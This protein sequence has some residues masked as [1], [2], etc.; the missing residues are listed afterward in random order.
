MAQPHM[1]LWELA[2]SEDNRVFSPYVW[3]VKL[4]LDAKVISL[5]LLVVLT[6]KHPN[7]STLPGRPCRS[8]PR[9][10][11]VAGP[12]VREGALALSSERLDP[13]VPDGTIPDLSMSRTASLDKPKPQNKFHCSQLSA[14]VP[15]LDVHG[16]RLHESWDIAQY[17]ETEFPGT[18]AF[19]AGDAPPDG[20]VKN[21]Q[22]ASFCFVIELKVLQATLT[23]RRSRPGEVRCPALRG[24]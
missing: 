12:G 23:L 10:L 13:A 19:R 6:V 24:S 8:S 11:R 17:L 16:K 7:G 1:K 4:V 14:Q 9:G 3:A 5:S 22:Y 15:V 21:W 20:H 18:N 2:A